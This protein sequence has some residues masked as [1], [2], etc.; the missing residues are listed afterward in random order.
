MRS[1]PVQVPVIAMSR[2]L[3]VFVDAGDRVHEGQVLVELDPSRLKIKINAAKAQ[4]ATAQAELERTRIGSAYILEKERPE[5]DIIRLQSATSEAGIRQ[6]LNT[7]YSQLSLEGLISKE[8]A[9]LKRIENNKAIG[10]L[11]EARLALNTAEEGRR[12]SLAIAE[13]A[14]RDAE[15]SLEYRENELRDYTVVAPADG[16]I[17]RRLVHSGEYNQDP[18]KPGFLMMSGLWFEAYL[19][20]TAIGKFS[21]GQQA[22][23][24]LEAFAGEEFGGKVTH[25]QPMVSY[26]LGGPETNRPIRPL[27]TGAPEWP[28]TFSIRIQLEP[29]PRLVPGLTGFARITIESHGSAVPRGAVQAVSGNKAIVFVV[30]ED[31]FTPTSV[32]TGESSNGW[33]QIVEGLDDDAEV[34]LDG[35]Q[36]LEPG[37]RIQVTN[38]YDSAF[39][40]SLRTE[41]RR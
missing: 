3:R 35:H 22:V 23:V 1:E 38:E 7:L 30:N 37:D 18:G 27:G 21:V 32:T 40:D 41:D 16:I 9:L 25:I 17:E 36:V 13:A 10:R 6:E 28:A 24:H 15:L 33:T 11:E 8:D 31:H 34:I 20:Q 26:S 14:L 29:N 12:Q 2:I 19:D 4:V 39:F 5:R